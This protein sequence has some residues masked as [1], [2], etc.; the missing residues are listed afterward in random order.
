MSDV[1]KHGPT[2]RVSQQMLD[3]F[4]G[5]GQVVQR[6]MRRGFGDA[7]FFHE[8]GL[9]RWQPNPFPQMRLFRWLP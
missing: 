7:L 2:I 1:V 6:A 5:M 3:D 9:P 4:A 8:V